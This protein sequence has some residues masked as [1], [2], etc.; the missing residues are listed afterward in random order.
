MVLVPK[1]ILAEEFVPGGL[2]PCGDS[3]LQSCKSCHLYQLV[4]NV[5]TWI[6]GAAAVVAAIIIVIG[7]MRMVTAGGNQMAKR[8]ARKWI[9]TAAVG[10][11]LIMSA[12]VLVELLIGTLSGQA[13]AGS[14]WSSF[15]CVE[16]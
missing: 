10:F 7:G 2:V 14:I 16:S 8:D 3:G 11:V 15:T 9:G 13:A 5:F 12:W 1:V 6:F 4:E